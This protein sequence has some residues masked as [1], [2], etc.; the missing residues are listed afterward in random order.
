MMITLIRHGESELNSKGIFQGR[1]DPDLSLKG[2]KQAKALAERLKDIRNV[3][4]FSSP[5]VRAHHTAR[6]VASELGTGITLIEDLKEIDIGGFSKR[7]WHEVQVSYPE[8]FKRP[9]VTIWD[10][11]RNDQIPGQEPYED[12]TQRIMQALSLIEAESNGFYPVI[13]GHGGF[14]RIFIAE[15]L[16]FR[17]IR[18]FLKI[19]NTSITLFEYSNGQATFYRIN[20]THHL[21]NPNLI[22]KKPHDSDNPVMI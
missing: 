13:F 5:L 3:R 7:T 21:Q 1:D 8:L 6:I 2:I 20:D 14:I 18:E 22:S 17:L 10:L 9:G 11:Y 4:L 19:D 12:M 16:G 15:Q